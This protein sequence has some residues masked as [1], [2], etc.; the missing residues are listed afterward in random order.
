MVILNNYYHNRFEIGCKRGISVYVAAIESRYF[1]TIIYVATCSCKERKICIEVYNQ[2]TSR[3]EAN[4]GAREDNT[5]THL[6][7]HDCKSC[8]P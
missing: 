6:R 2:K 7:E 1:V 4:L 3:E 8:T 5:K